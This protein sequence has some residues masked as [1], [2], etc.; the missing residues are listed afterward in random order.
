MED[1]K[2]AVPLSF[3]GK[4]LLNLGSIMAPTE[5]HN[6]IA[7]TC[8]Y[9]HHIT[10]GTLR[11]WLDLWT[12]RWGDYPGISSWRPIVREPFLGRSER[13]VTIEGSERGDTSIQC[14]SVG[15]ADGS[16]G[17]KAKECSEWSLDSGDN[18]Q[19]TTSKI[20]GTLVLRAQETKFCQQPEWTGKKVLPWFLCKGV[21]LWWQLDFS[22]VT[23][24][25]D[26]WLTE[27]PDKYVC[28]SLGQVWSFASYKL[29]EILCPECQCEEQV[30]RSDRYRIRIFTF[31]LLFLK[32]SLDS[33]HRRKY[34]QQN[35]INSATN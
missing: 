20:M 23:S 32:Y 26:V 28:V 5:A 18:P 27:L 34:S 25:L 15:F 16:R 29:I 24:M 30:N 8:E 22:P 33:Y 7:P 35:F 3:W 12:L 6:L 10:K 4:M 14:T 13:N 17:Q 9:V 2:W 11:M 21:Q 31:Q 1:K 19:F